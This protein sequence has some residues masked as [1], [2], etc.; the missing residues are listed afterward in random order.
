M[1]YAAPWQSLAGIVSRLCTEC[2]T[3]RSIC[4]PSKL[5]LNSLLSIIFYLF[6]GDEKLQEKITITEKRLEKEVPVVDTEQE[7]D[8]SQCFPHLSADTC[9]IH[10]SLV[11]P[12]ILLSTSQ[13]RCF[14]NLGERKS[15]TALVSLNISDSLKFIHFLSPSRPPTLALTIKLIGV[16]VQRKKN[17]LT[18][19]CSMEV[20]SWKTNKL[21][22]RSKVGI[23]VKTKMSVLIL[24]LCSRVVVMRWGG[25]FWMERGCTLETW[26]WGWTIVVIN[27]WKHNSILI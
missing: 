6:L 15:S 25:G 19:T 8:V 20:N 18:L 3:Q 26:G 5:C 11:L 16:S 7:Y 27:P 22:S 4:I 17:S 10:L 12:A 23:H 1:P 14:I 13:C 21:L 24:V 9:L 2:R